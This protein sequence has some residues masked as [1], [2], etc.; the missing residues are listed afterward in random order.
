MIKIFSHQDLDGYGV[1]VIARLADKEVFSDIENHSYETIN[2]RVKKF[3]ENKE[4]EAYEKI[5]ITDMSVSKENAKLINNLEEKDK[6]LLIDHHVPSSDWLKEYD[7]TIIVGEINNNKV[8]GTWLFYYEFLDFLKDKNCKESLE[9]LLQQGILDFVE[10]VRLYDTW[11]WTKVSKE[12]LNKYNPEELNMLLLIINE[13]NFINLFTKVLEQGKYYIPKEE[14]KLID[15]EKEIKNNY[16]KGILKEVSLKRYKD[17]NM[18]V[19]SADKYI[20]DLGKFIMENNVLELDFVMI[21]NKPK[22]SL[23]TNKPHINVCNIAK[24][25]GGGGHPQ[26]S[27][28]TY[29][30]ELLKEFL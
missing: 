3:I 18:G 17:L 19:V 1:N 9:I 4:Y 28:F 5:Y 2:E 20:S 25:Y 29:N 13:V 21:I 11:D 23:R 30:E 16:M 27:G 26:A 10:A 15:E 14:M 8:S 22:V 12:I 6:F 7:W 24:E